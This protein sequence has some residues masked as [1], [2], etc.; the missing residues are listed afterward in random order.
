MRFETRTR[1]WEGIGYGLIFVGVT[2]PG[3]LPALL[4]WWGR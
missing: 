2:L 3:W 1:I 4:E